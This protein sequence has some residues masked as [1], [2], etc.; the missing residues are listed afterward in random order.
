MI[1]NEEMIIF[2]K[3]IKLLINEYNKCY[4]VKIKEQIY[5]EIIVLSDL[6]DT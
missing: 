6:I 1:S 3:Q 5:E 2:M 4:D